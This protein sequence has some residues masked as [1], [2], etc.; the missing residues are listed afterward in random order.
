MSIAR[1]VCS[2]DFEADDLKQMTN[3]SD[4]HSKV[5]DSQPQYIETQTF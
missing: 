5:V 4:V 1:L 3:I 2:C